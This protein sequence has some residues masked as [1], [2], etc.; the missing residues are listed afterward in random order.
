MRQSVTRQPAATIVA[1]ACFALLAACA[2]HPAPAAKEPQPLAGQARLDQGRNL[3]M[4]RCARCHGLPDPACCG[5]GVMDAMAPQAGLK[6]DER[7]AVE[8]YL[9]SALAKK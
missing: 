6:P 7:A 8:A 9:K 2:G 3:F 4:S 1:L 5:K